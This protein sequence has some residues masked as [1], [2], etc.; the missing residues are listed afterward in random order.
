MIHGLDEYEKFKVIRPILGNHGVD[1]NH[2]PVMHKV[3]EDMININKAVPLNIKNL[4]AK[5]NNSDKLVLPFNY[6]KDIL[7]YWNDP[8]KYIP[9]LQT[10]LA[11][12]TPD[13]SAYS[14]MN[15]N[16]IQHNVYMNRWLGCLW[17]DYGVKALPTIPWALPDTYDICFG[18]VEKGGIVII[19]TVGASEHLDIFYDGFY[20][21][22]ETIEPSLIIVYGE[23]LPDMYGRFVHYSYQEAF[24][25]NRQAYKQMCLFDPTTIF[26][27]KRG[28][29]YGK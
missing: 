1:A 22:K 2:L 17:Q 20:A 15:P 5:Y 3:T 9:V 14:S 25:S 7:K 6:D 23:M 13:Y 21:M 29:R 12:G 16:E 27:R 18:G 26:E 11:V 28:N 19:S 4:S 8:L 24:N 10:T